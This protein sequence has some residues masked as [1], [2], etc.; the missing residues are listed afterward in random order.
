MSLVGHI[1]VVPDR[2]SRDLEAVV[3]RRTINLGVGNLEL[4]GNGEGLNFL[5]LLMREEASKKSTK[6]EG[7]RKNKAASTKGKKKGKGKTPKGGNGAAAQPEKK[8]TREKEEERGAYG[9]PVRRAGAGSATCP[10]RLHR[11]QGQGTVSSWSA[12]SD[13][14]SG[15]NDNVK[16]GVF[17]DRRSW[18]LEVVVVRRTI[19]LGVGNLEWGGNGE[20]LRKGGQFT[21]NLRPRWTGSCHS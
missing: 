13:A 19:N 11:G 9:K 15:G 4:G 20:G 18:D 3:V 21:S 10:S 16:R 5:E 7:T 6:G 14:R 17:P 12:E 2:R 8:E 1:I